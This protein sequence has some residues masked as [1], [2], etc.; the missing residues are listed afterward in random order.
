[1]ANVRDYTCV[2]AVFQCIRLLLIFI[3]CRLTYVEWHKYIIEK[4]GFQTDEISSWVV[5]FSIC[6]GIFIYNVLFWIFKVIMYTC[7]RCELLGA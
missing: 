4:G 1:M 5:V 3:S 2:D 7:F 6:V